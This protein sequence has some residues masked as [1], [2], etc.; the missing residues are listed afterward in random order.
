MIIN[1]LL[2]FSV[3]IMSTIKTV[4]I[5]LKS[6]SHLNSIRKDFILKTKKTHDRGSL[7]LNGA[8]FTCMF[9]LL[10]LFFAIKFKVE[11][12]E[13]KYRSN[14]YLC[15]NYLNIKT[16]NYIYD[17]TALNWLLRS[18]AA[19]T[20]SGAAT[21]QAKAAHKILEISRDA[22]HTYF[23]KEL[24]TSHYCSKE[25]VI[26]ALIK[27]PYKARGVVKLETNIDGTTIIRENKWKRQLFKSPAGIRLKK[28]FCLQSTFEM[29]GIMIPNLKITTSESSVGFLNGGI[30]KLKCLSGF[31]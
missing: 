26:P 10:L 25:M 19:A 4:D 29:A 18:T 21:A 24:F 15:M 17:I 31:Q 8:L 5:F 27:L 20:L 30:S 11:L 13:S 16:A 7:S 3:L 28:S 22:R 9:S 12:K 6:N 14:S 23:L 2:A 1:Y